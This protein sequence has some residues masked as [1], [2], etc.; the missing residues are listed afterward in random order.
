MIED[1][2]VALYVL[3]FMILLTRKRK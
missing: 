1:K 2:L 3:I